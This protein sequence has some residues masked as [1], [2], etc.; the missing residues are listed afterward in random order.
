VSF[1]KSKA[2]TMCAVLDT[3]GPH[4][5]YP[6]DA[7]I[8]EASGYLRS[9]IDEIDRLHAMLSSIRDVMPSVALYL[10]ALASMIAAECDA[11]TRAKAG[12][13]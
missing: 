8:L 1:N 7:E 9:A 2:R 11:A 5:Y 4:S 6:T 10:P 12:E 13:P 3:T